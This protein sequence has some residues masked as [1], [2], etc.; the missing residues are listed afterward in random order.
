MSARI[1]VVAE[2]EGVMRWT[3]RLLRV[4]NHR[5]PCARPRSSQPVRSGIHWLGTMIAR[6]VVVTVTS[7]LAGYADAARA[8]ST[9]GTMNLD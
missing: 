3:H 1:R 5:A 7:V 8:R 6:G 4:A 2:V 9:S